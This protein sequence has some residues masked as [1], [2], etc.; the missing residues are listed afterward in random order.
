MATR[1][2]TVAA[3]L[4]SGLAVPAAG[5]VSPPRLRPKPSVAFVVQCGLSH[6]APDD[7]LQHPGH[8]GMSHQHSFF[9]NGSTNSKSTA[10]SLAASKK[11]SCDTAG[12]RAAYW[13]PSPIGARWVSMRAYYDAGTLD[14]AS[15][16]SFPK[17]LSMIAGE[18]VGS[19]AWSCGRS[20]SAAGWT[21]MP[22]DCG[23]P[24]PVT[25]MVTFPQCWDGKQ[26]YRP[27]TRHMA[28]PISGVCP[29]THPVALPRLR[30][31]FRLSSSKVPEAISA[32]PVESMHADFMN[33]WVV[34]DLA[35][36]VAGCIR[37][38]RAT[39][40]DLRSC[41]PKTA[42]PRPL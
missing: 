16:K 21:D 7:P 42:E 2:I 24:R 31:V 33:S 11:S 6:E 28:V 23:A 34:G 26:V 36:L 18:S 20:P 13:T 38:E 10:E 14:P 37:G 35:K 17:G 30:L 15:I 19:V 3:L 32:G 27:G 4:L 5:G 29:K 22:V 1:A 41:R 40:S 25:A 39:S 8:S 12:D 9:G